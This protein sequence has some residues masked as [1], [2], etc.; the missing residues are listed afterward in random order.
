MVWRG[1]NSDAKARKVAA[2]AVGMGGEGMM[3][4]GSNDKNRT[5]GK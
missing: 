5:S 4:D 1:P 3:G 2:M